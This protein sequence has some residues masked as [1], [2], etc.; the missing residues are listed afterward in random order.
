MAMGF[1]SA[2][3]VGHMPRLLVQFSISAELAVSF[4]IMSVA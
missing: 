1:V 3:M 2:A 4:A